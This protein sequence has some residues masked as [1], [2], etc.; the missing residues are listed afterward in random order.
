MSLSNPQVKNP[1]TRFMQWRGGEDG[2]GRVTWY[3]KEAEEE[4][5]M[6]LPFSFIV[7]DE[8]TTITGFSEKDHSGFWSNEVRNTMTDELVVR[9][10]AGI[11]ARGLYGKISE[12]IKAKG[13][14]YATSV[15]IAFKDESGELVIGN[16]K[17]AGAALT[18]WIEFKKKFD[19][20]QCAVYLNDKPKK[21][22][23]GSTTYFIPV[24]EGQELGDATK[25]AA[26][27]LDE[28]LQRYLNTYLSRK[29]DIEETVDTD[30]DD[31]EIEDIHDIEGLDKPAEP[32]TP[33]EAPAP[34][35]A[36][37]ETGDK[38]INLKDVPF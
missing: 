23:K 26:I 8:L 19:V 29:P 31:I 1:A 2:G 14:K 32:E 6:K 24:F 38:T 18:A 5:E 27:R 10:K 20:S 3:D 15:Y 9:T 34:A 36:P 25:K 33:A 11:V 28:D 35:A 17:V 30:D 7:L 12:S 22:K 4:K 16:F 37:K 21:G 13:A